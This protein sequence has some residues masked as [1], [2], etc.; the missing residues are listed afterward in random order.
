MLC[1]NDNIEMIPVK[2]ESHYGQV[3][4]LDQCKQ[5]GGIWFDKFE[6]SRAR[7]DQSNKIEQLDSAL[8]SSPTLISSSKLLCPRD[9]ASLVPFNDAY[10]PR[11]IIIAKCTVCE[12]FWLNRGEFTKY[13][14]A[15]LAA[16]QPREV[17]VSNTNNQIDD[18]LLKILAQ[19]ESG[20]STRTL[21]RLS[22]FLSTPVDKPVEVVT[23][24]PDG[25]IDKS[26]EIASSAEQA[27]ST[28]ISILM[29][30]LRLF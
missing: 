30:V 9:H 3:I 28:G 23:L 22:K 7:L 27:V 29:M 20:N 24:N 13:Q 5:C 17:T 6:L 21:E 11:G 26:E 12:G 1:P 14:R 18:K 25:T 10:F 16:K 8:L 19:Y 15:R 2:I 4:I